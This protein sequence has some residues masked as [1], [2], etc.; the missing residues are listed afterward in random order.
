MYLGLLAASML[1]IHE[2]LCCVRDHMS[3]TLV[4]VCDLGHVV[5]ERKCGHCTLAFCVIVSRIQRV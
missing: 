1:G 4:K 5:R 2:Q 3:M